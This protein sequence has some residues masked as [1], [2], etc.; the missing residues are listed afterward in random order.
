[1]E[2]TIR[3]E[4]MTTHEPLKIEEIPNPKMPQ[5]TTN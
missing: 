1:M 5:S 3:D 4:L 2:I